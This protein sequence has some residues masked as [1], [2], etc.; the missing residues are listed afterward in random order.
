MDLLS[1]VMRQ[2]PWSPASSWPARPESDGGTG[3]GSC[4]HTA[5]RTSWCRKGC[6]PEKDESKNPA[7]NVPVSQAHWMR[8]VTVTLFDQHLFVKLD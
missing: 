2:Q 5:C 7:M 4:S 8:L 1:D 6:S 3:P